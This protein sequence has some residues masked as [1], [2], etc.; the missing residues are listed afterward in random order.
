MPRVNFLA[1]RGLVSY[2]FELIQGALMKTSVENKS[3]LLKRITVEVPSEKVTSSFDRVYKDIQK[4]ATIK[5]FRKGK[6]PIATIKAIYADSVKKDVLQDLLSETYGAAIREHKLQPVTQP[7]VN[8]D[9]ELKEESAFTFTAEF[10]VHPE[11]KVKKFEKLKVEKEKWTLDETEV[12]KVVDNYRQQGAQLVPIFEERPVQEG[13]TAVIDFVGKIEG[14]PFEGGS[15]Q[16]YPLELGSKNFIPGFEEAIVGMK[17]GAQKAIPLRFP[18]D[19]HAEFA[20]KD[21]VFDVTLKTIKKKSLPELNDEF[22][23]T[24]AGFPTVEAFKQDI[25]DRMTEGE[26]KR[27]QSDLRSRVIQELVKQNP[28]EVPQQIL[29]EEKEAMMQ[30]AFKNLSQRGMTA[31]QFA[32]YKTKWEK[33]FNEAASVKVQAN[34]LVMSLSETLNLTAS[35]KDVDERI[36]KYAKQIGMEPAKVRAFYEK[37][38]SGLSGLQ[39]QIIEEKVV[40]HLLQT[41]EVKEV[42]KDQLTDKQ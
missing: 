18:D 32:E 1:L 37:S 15:A 8:F 13:D 3:G 11:V 12:D 25:R 42:S 30:D 26:E 36:E 17:T 14:T 38:P 35:R 41:A 31:E 40:D 16:D 24:S 22:A 33:D 2:K 28:L 27:I 20:G 6:A 21:V 7:A 9:G 29:N 34:F 10:E 39:Y 23:N 5:G 4:N 19:Y